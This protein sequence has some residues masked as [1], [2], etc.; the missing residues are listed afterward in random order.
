MNISIFHDGGSKFWHPIAEDWLNKDHIIRHCPNY[1]V[2]RNFRPNLILFEYCNNNVFRY[3]NQFVKEHGKA[4]KV[5]VRAHGVGI[6]YNIYKFVNWDYVDD[7][8]FVSDHLKR[9][10]D[11]WDFKNTQIHIVH[12]GI[13]LNRFTLKKSFKPTYKL[14]YVGR[15]VPFKGIDK[16]PEIV[17]RF[18]KVD[19]RYELYCATGNIK[20]INTWLEDKDYLIHP[21][22]IES[23]S[24]VVGEALAKGIRPLI[25]KWEGAEEIWGNEFFIDDFNLEQDPLRFRKIIE[26][27][28]DQKRMIKEINKICGIG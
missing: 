24:Y 27:K 8:I 26:D 9:M 6:R 18:K 2:W 5:V 4:K 20:D 25:N 28:Y 10:T 19:S 22:T 13:N 14:A 16:L 7:L 3:T 15:W 1:S 12:N 17:E 11:G 21:S 23:F